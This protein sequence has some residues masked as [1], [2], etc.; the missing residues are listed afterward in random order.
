MEGRNMG[1]SACRLSLLINDLALLKTPFIKDILNLFMEDPLLSSSAKDQ[2]PFLIEGEYEHTGVG[3]FVPFS[4]ELGIR[5]HQVPT[6][7]LKL[8]G[9]HIISSELMVGADATLFFKEGLIDF[10]SIWALGSDF[11]QEG[12]TDYT[13]ERMAPLDNDVMD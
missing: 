7:D 9:V 11:P 6:Q 5:L 1:I 3:L 2:L 12:L 13:L 4:H 10:L 8:V